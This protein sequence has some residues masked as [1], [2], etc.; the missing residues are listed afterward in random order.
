MTLF[1]VSPQITPIYSASE[2]SSKLS[3]AT[4]TSLYLSIILLPIVAVL[5]TFAASCDLRLLFP[6]IT[7]LGMSSFCVVLAFL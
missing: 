6:S 1:R 2:Y 5:P 3:V 4:F 7:S